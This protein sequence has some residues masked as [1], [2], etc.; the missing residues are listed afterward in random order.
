MQLDNNSIIDIHDYVN[1]YE[2]KVLAT[3]LTTSFNNIKNIYLDEYSETIFQAKARIN[4]Q[5]LFI[6]FL[7][8]IIN[9][10]VYK[11][12]WQKLGE[13]A[14]NEEDEIEDSFLH[15]EKGT[16]KQE[17]WHWFEEKFNISVAKDLM[18]I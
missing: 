4:N 15:F 2:I 10:Y 6:E 16:D 14:V 9:Q 8:N 7:K 11:K 1:Q 13:I 17:I 12:L 3:T 5:K 18:N